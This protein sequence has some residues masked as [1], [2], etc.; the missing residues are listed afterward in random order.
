[1]EK[2]FN[3]YDVTPDG[4][5]FSFRSGKELLGCVD[6]DGYKKV[7]PRINGVKYQLKIHRLVAIKYLPNPNNLPQVNHKDGN[8]FNNHVENL[9]WCN[10]KHNINHAH[11]TGLSTNEHLKKAVKQI[12]PVTG[13]VIATYSSYREASQTTGISETNISAVCRNYKPKNRPN[14]RKTAGGFRW[15]TCND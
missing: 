2:F 4:R 12:D 3:Y 6:S 13:D 14:P 9:E 11:Q 1:M 7:S 8:K 10:A 5:V 15:E